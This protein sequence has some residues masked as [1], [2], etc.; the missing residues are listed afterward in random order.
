M[1]I[2]IPVWARGPDMAAAAADNATFYH[3][4]NPRESPDAHLAT[5]RVQRG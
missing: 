2:A 1:Y 5:L 4:R 3:P